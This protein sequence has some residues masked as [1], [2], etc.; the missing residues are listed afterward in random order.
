MELSDLLTEDRIAI[1]VK[2]DNWEEAIRQVGQLMVD[3]GV[4]EDRYIDGMIRTTKEL[5]PYIVIAPGLAIPHSRPED[6]VIHTCYAIATLET[7]VEFGNSD[8]DPVYA[9]IAL[10]AKDHE[11]HVSALQTVAEIL[12]VPENLEALK[13]ADSKD[14]V[15]RI[16]GILS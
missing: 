7:P 4:V 16:M 13:F 6:G 11:E 10:G 8:N 1:K 9:M 5:G 2:A 3:T 14:D 15:M 12:M